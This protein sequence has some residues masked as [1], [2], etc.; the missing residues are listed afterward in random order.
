M[1]SQVSQP[2]IATGGQSYRVNS[3]KPLQ[4]QDHPVDGYTPSKLAP[5]SP[6]DKPVVSGIKPSP[7]ARLG[8]AIGLVA[9]PVPGPVG[10]VLTLNSLKEFAHKSTLE[11][12]EVL[13]QS[14]DQATDQMGQSSGIVELPTGVPTMV[15]P[16]IHAQRDYLVRA[17][18]HEVNG[19]KVFDLLKQG[20]MNLLILGDG[21]HSEARGQMRWRT[22]EHDHM[23]GQKNSPAMRDEVVESF[24]TM[25]M[26]M[27]L[28]S[29][30]GDHLVYLRGNHDDI[31]G[32]YQ[33]FC[34]NVGESTLMHDW[35]KNHYGKDL[36]DKWVAFEESMPLVA[37]GT[38][39]VASHAAPGTALQREEIERRDDRAFKVLT[40]TDNTAWDEHGAKRDIFGRNLEAVGGGEFD[41]WLVGHRKVSGANY[42][43]QFDNALIQINPTDAEGFVVAMIGADGKFDPNTDTFKV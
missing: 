23:S 29:E 39:F 40:W 16:D 15:I 9:A 17:M 34:G 35:V 5:P 8:M 12:K 4:Q 7:L 28:K 32:A 31:D 11:D 22:A 19:E 13:M 42:R 21:M 2:Q 1:I 43:G 24:G 3:G 38:G 27:D 20:K 41:R 33:K 25:K 14:L 30:M 37:K 6:Y 36:V 26:V 18:E 10:A